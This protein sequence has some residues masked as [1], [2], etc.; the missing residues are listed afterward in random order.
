MIAGLAETFQNAI[1]ITTTKRRISEGKVRIDLDRTTEMFDCRVEMFALNGVIDE[2]CE[3]VAPAQVLFG[4]GGVRSRL[5]CQFVFFIRAQL[6]SQAF[7]DAMHDGVLY[8]D[9]V[10]GIRVDALAPKDFTRANVE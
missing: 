8:A 9:D 3:A 4:G 7:D 1:D 6:E 10:A 5:P 2:L